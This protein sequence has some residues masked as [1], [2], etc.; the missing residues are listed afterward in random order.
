MMK[1]TGELRGD[2]MCSG[3]G[4]GRKHAIFKNLRKLRYPEWNYKAKR[5]TQVAEA[6][7]PLQTFI[8]TKYE[9]I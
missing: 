2:S 5:Y 6:R 8:D 7:A 4:N 1:D 9:T 3:P